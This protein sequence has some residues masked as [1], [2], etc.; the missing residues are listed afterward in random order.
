MAMDITNDTLWHPTSLFKTV[1]DAVGYPQPVSL[2]GG[3]DQQLLLI[4]WAL[5]GNAVVSAI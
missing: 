3:A 2:V 5:A 4:V 1:T